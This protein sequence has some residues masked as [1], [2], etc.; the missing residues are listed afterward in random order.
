MVLAIGDVDAR[1]FHQHRL[2]VLAQSEDLNGVVLHHVGLAFFQ[3]L[4]IQHV[5]HTDF[6][7]FLVHLLPHGH[8]AVLHLVDHAIVGD[9][10]QGAFVLEDFRHL[11]AEQVSACHSLQRN[12]AIGLF[13][14]LSEIVVSAYPDGVVGGSVDHGDTCDSRC[15]D[16]APF[17]IV[18]VE[19]A[20]EIG[21]EHIAIFVN[22]DI[23][24][25][26]VGVV[27]L[28]REIADEGDTLPPC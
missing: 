14:H 10:L 19:Q 7:Q 4:D 24:V 12:L 18:V 3:C 8:L 2:Q 16:N 15:M 20:F 25:G 22:L 21:H 28:H 5:E 9:K 23:V 11:A 26:V 1:I 6:Q 27:I 17:G 13:H